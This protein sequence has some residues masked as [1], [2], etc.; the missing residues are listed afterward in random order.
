MHTSL[1]TQ[2]FGTLNLLFFTRTCTT[3]IFLDT[4]K[5]QHIS[6]SGFVFPLHDEIRRIEPDSIS[7]GNDASACGIWALSEAPNNDRDYC[8]VYDEIDYTGSKCAVN[9]LERFILRQHPRLFQNL[10]LW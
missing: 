9:T 10:V 1:M 4:F 6:Y 2:S 7:D 5:A 3:Y 8:K